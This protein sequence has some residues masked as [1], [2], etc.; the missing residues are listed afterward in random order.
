MEE[1]YRIFQG[2][3]QQLIHDHSG[4][5]QITPNNNTPE[6]AWLHCCK[7]IECGKY[8]TIPKEIPE[9]S[10]ICKHGKLSDI[11]GRLWCLSFQQMVKGFETCEKFTPKK[12]SDYVAIKREI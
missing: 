6:S 2:H 3:L 9:T 8:T 5:R 10:S 12:D 7:A 11:P 1:Y 4:G